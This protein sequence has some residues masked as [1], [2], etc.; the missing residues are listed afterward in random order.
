MR[1]KLDKNSKQM[2]KLKLKFA[3]VQEMNTSEMKE[4]NGGIIPLI[5][6]AQTIGVTTGAVTAVGGI[7]LAFYTI[8]KRVTN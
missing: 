5:A 3:A 6:L 7:G 8:Y 4:L 2:E 1:N